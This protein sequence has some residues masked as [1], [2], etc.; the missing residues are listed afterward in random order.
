M[1]V[2]M[3]EWEMGHLFGRGGGVNEAEGSA[4]VRLGFF[5]QSDLLMTCVKQF[6]SFSHPHFP[7]VKGIY[8]FHNSL[9]LL[10]P[11]CLPPLTDKHKYFY[12]P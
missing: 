4:K 2:M 1:N 3:V 10:P 9:G 12:S 7:K 6:F 8:S 11:I 5:D